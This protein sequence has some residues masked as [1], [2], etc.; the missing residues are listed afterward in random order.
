MLFLLAPSKSTA[1]QGR[2]AD[3]KVAPRN[4]INDILSMKSKFKKFKE[5]RCIFLGNNNRIKYDFLLI[6]HELYMISLVS[7]QGC[8][9]KTSM[10]SMKS[11]MILV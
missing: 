10:D 9:K 11:D 4:H 6:T 7:C 5:E 3:H 8:T 2:L 1:L